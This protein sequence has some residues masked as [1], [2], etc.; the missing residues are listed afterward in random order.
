MAA[1]RHHAARRRLH[2]G[3]AG[4]TH[5]R[6]EPPHALA[7]CRPNGVGLHRIPDIAR[8]HDK[9]YGRRWKHRAGLPIMASDAENH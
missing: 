6:R 3:R 5:R 4:P 7:R 8:S 9:D 2:A 1:C